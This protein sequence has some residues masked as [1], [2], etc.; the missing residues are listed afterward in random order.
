M[1]LPKAIMPFVCSSAALYEWCG[2]AA[3]SEKTADVLKNWLARDPHDTEWSSVGLIDPVDTGR[4]VHDLDGT[5]R[6]LVFQFNDRVLPG[7][8]IKEK[9]KERVR[10][11]EQKQGFKLTKK[12]FAEVKQE[13]IDQLL[14]SAFIRRTEVP[15]FVMKDLI[16]V[17]HSSPKK[18][19][20]IL[21]HIIRLCEFRKIDWKWQPFTTTDKPS[22]MLHELSHGKEV[23][24]NEG[25]TR[26]L[27]MPGTTAVFTG[28]DKRTIRVKNREMMSTEVQEIINAG[29][30]RTTEVGTYLWDDGT[31]RAHFIFTENWVLKSV[32]CET[33]SAGR[34]AGDVHATYWLFAQEMG[35]VVRLIIDCLNHGPSPDDDESL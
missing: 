31:E 8:V 32:K 30:Y 9:M 16:L 15:V 17:C 6:V 3:R 4:P 22:W 18:V 19:E 27:F 14:P 5:A 20:A 24:P 11:L 10:E 28:E 21:G 26:L 1:K 35:N 34:E 13:T 25:D 33:K 2:K 7:A 23:E 12:N 29:G